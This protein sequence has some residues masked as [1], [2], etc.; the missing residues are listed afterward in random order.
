M[1]K[2]IYQGD[3][4]DLTSLSDAMVSLLASPGEHVKSASASETFPDLAQFMPDKDH[5]LM[6]LVAVGS[7][8]RYGANRNGD[9]FPIQAL[10]DYHHTFVKCSNLYK[11][12]RNT[13]PKLRIGVVKASAVHPSLER[14]ELL[15]HGHIKSAEE[16]YQ[17]AKEG[18]ELSFSMSCRVKKDYCN[19]CGN[20]A[21]NRSEYCF[22]PGTMITLADGRITE[23]EKIQ[24]GDSV[25]SA[26]G[27]P[28]TVTKLFRHVVSEPILQ[29]KNSLSCVATGVTKEHPFLALPGEFGGVFD[30]DNE[31]YNSRIN[32]EPL[33]NVPGWEAFIA[34]PQFVEAEFLRLKDFLVA[35]VLK[36]DD[37]LWDGFCDAEAAWIYGLFTAEGSFGKHPD[38][39]LRALQF[40]IHQDETDFVDRLAAYFAKLGKNICV[41]G[42]AASKGVDVRVH[43]QDIAEKFREICGEYATAKTVDPRFLHAPVDIQLAYLRGVYDGDGHIYNER[44]L[45]AGR[46]YSRINSASKQ[47]ISQLW[48]MTAQLGC[49]NYTGNYVQAGGPSNRTNRSPSWYLSSS[50]LGDT[51]V[52]SQGKGFLRGD[53]I[54]YINQ[55]SEVLY[56]G[57][58]FNFET[59]DHTYVANGLAVHNCGHLLH[60][61][62]QYIPEFQKYAFARNLEPNFFDISRVR[63]PADRIAHYLQYKFPDESDLQKAA[64]QAGVI[65]GMDW[66]EYEGLVIPDNGRVLLPAKLA[67]LAQ[68]LA[69]E[70]QWFRGMIEDG[71][72]MSDAKSAFAKEAGLR[73]FEGELTDEE[74][75]ALRKL[76]PGDMFALLAKEAASLPF[77]S[78]CAYITNKSLDEVSAEA[79]SASLYLPDVFTKLADCGSCVD[80]HSLCAPGDGDAADEDAVNKFM[81]SV[82]DRFSC[83]AEPVRRRVFSISISFGSFARPSMP[84]KKA[85]AGAAVLA[86]MYGLYKLAAI[87]ANPDEYGPA[88]RLLMVAQNQIKVK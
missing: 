83:K 66:A 32:D 18:K 68:E 17:L 43:G 80:D 71:F 2:T 46:S 85:S 53:V 4:E 48:H 28:T 5:F 79:G 33:C 36:K 78:F 11:E 65:N 8:G 76:P 25:L 42:K 21:R 51:D 31:K 35:P 72:C 70:E 39:R 64:S 45:T 47:L 74:L 3:Q 59:E 60:E 26:L 16:E 49:F 55:I 44:K 10:N 14:V 62:N 6:H 50:F 84:D 7:E 56:S 58:V 61:M 9:S 88:Q 38:G 67:S 73:A 69:Q 22:V 23:I 52:Q 87:A 24:V 57:D 29:L 63:Y 77:K 1:R 41:Y 37:T 13:D 19:A 82:T 34:S 75:N 54:G 15:V 30:I 86:E 27:Q 20:A 12:H 81:E 40:S